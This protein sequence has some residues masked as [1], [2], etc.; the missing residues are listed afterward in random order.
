MTVNRATLHH[1]SIPLKGRFHTATGDIGA[2]E[3]GILEVETDSAVGWGE[4]PP[5]PGQDESF[6][7]VLEA[8][9]NGSTTPTLRTAIEFALVD[10]SARADGQSLGSVMGVTRNAIPAS[11][12]VGLGG[13]PR[14]MVE[15]AAALGVSRFKVKVAPG[16]VL[17]VADVV[18]AQPQAIVGVDANGSFDRTTIEELEAIADLGIAYLEQPCSPSDEA[19]LDRLRQIIDAPV[20][21]DETVRSASDATLALSSTLINGVVV[22]PGRL[23]FAGSL[24]TIAEVDRRGKRWRASGLL[25]SGIGRSFSDL[26][27]GLPTAFV[28]DVAPANWFFERDIVETRFVDGQMLLP[29]GPGIGVEPDPDLM[30]RYR[31]QTID[32]TESVRRW[33]ALDRG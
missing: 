14:A 16:H 2:R 25:E 4:A 24:A 23:G 19:T 20:F 6:E 27:A 32:A 33:E 18:D 21:A 22:K 31:I 15:S 9:T 29:T 12:A 3:F 13:D 17:H 28:S 1:L 5:Y 11:I 7:S 8:V 10:A 26:F 30:D